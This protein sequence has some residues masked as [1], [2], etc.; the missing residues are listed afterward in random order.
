MFLKKKCLILLIAT[1]I[2]QSVKAGPIITY[3]D[4]WKKQST[5][6]KELAQTAS[7][8]NKLT[9]KPLLVQIQIP[10]FLREGDRI[11]LSAKVTNFSDHELTGT[12]Q[13]TLL[14]AAT[15]QSVDGWFKNIFPTQ[16][17]TVAVGQSLDIKFPIEIPY[18]F[19]SALKYQVTATTNPP[20]LIKEPIN[21]NDSL[22]SLI[23]SN[24]NNSKSK[25]NI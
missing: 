5:I 9:Q 1:S 17:F 11:E 25:E 21:K 3:S 18:N 19:N 16:Y 15:N 14:N 12:T 24:K 23:S 20:K 10:N 7:N 4:F 6:K 8:K 2:T 13:L 22:N